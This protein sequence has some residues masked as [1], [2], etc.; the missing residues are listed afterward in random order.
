LALYVGKSLSKVVLECPFG[1]VLEF[2]ER[3]IL[4]IGQYQEGK[5]YAY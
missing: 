2:C 4:H 5:E 3:S 1:F